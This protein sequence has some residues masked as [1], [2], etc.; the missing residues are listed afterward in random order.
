VTLPVGL[1]VF[2]HVPAWKPEHLA[3]AQAQDEHRHVPPCIADRLPARAD[4]SG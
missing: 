3:L 4:S 1:A 2:D